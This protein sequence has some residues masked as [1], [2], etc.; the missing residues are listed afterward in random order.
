MTKVFIVMWCSPHIAKIHNRALADAR[1]T[2][3][4]AK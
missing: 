4:G 2:E 1:A 3:G